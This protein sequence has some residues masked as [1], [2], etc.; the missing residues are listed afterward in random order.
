[1]LVHPRPWSLT[2]CSGASWNRG[3]GSEHPEEGPHSISPGR[4]RVE[5]ERSRHCFGLLLIWWPWRCW[6]FWILPLGSMASLRH[7]SCDRHEQ[8]CQCTGSN[9]SGS[10]KVHVEMGKVP[11]R[12]YNIQTEC[13]MSAKCEAPA[14]DRE[15]HL[16][17][18]GPTTPILSGQVSPKWLQPSLWD[19]LET[20]FRVHTSLF[21]QS[22]ARCVRV[23]PAQGW[24]GLQAFVTSILSH[25]HA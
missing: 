18:P 20:W 25:S 17:S 12:L 14:R 6:W 7:L 2:C 16:S 3:V 24:G 4:G 13:K 10:P 9:A 21:L 23:L 22:P 1:M 19:T 5:G 11:A 15:V 8:G